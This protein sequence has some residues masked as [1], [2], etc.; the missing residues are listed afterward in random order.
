MIRIATDFEEEDHQ[1]SQSHCSKIQQQ[2][3]QLI[4]ALLVLF[5][6]E[7]EESLNLHGRKSFIPSGGEDGAFQRNPMALVCPTGIRR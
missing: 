2:T 1:L 3:L 5:I 7:V 6:T 4:G